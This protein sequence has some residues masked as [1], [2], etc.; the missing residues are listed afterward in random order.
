MVLRQD[1]DGNGASLLA[2]PATCGST[3]PVAARSRINS[4]YSDG[5][6]VLAATITQELGIP[7][8]HYV[9]VDFSGFKDLVDAVGGTEICFMYADP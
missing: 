1:Q 2:C 6:D 8:H 4:A 7:I 9:E 3:S 5:P